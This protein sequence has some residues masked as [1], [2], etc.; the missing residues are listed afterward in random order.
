LVLLETELIIEFLESFVGILGSEFVE[1]LIIVVS[2]G[3]IGK[4]KVSFIDVRKLLLSS[5]P[6]LGMLLRVPFSSKFLIGALN[7]V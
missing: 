1:K 3:K 7:I 2:S 4:H 5:D 6:I